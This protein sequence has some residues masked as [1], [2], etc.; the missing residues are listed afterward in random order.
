MRTTT[1]TSQ[2]PLIYSSWSPPTT[3]DP[4]MTISSAWRSTLSS[5]LFTQEREDTASRR[6]VY[7]S[8]DED[9]SSSPSSS[10]G[11]VRT[12]RL[13]TDQFDSQILNV[14]VELQNEICCT[15]DSRDFEDAESV[16]CGQSHVTS[17][18]VFSHL[19]QILGNSE[20]PATMSRQVFGTRMVRR[21]TFVHK[22]MR[23]LQ[24]LI[25]KNW[26]ME[27]IDR[28]VAPFIHSGQKWKAR[29][30]SRSEMPVWTVSHRFSHLQ[31]RRLFK[32]LWDRPTTT[33]DFWFPLWQIS[34]TSNL[35][36]LED[37]VQNRGMY[38]FK[39]SYG[40]NAMDQRSGVGW[41]SGWIEIFVIFSWYFNAEFWSTWCE[42]SFS[43]EPNHPCFSRSNG[44]TC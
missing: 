31:W 26:I 23:H 27:F 13:V 3:T 7:H 1:H 14:R 43:I 20:S 36:L 22:Q 24:L 44:E 19:I 40:S 18:P 17:Q 16:R 5:S 28:R 10:V 15:N 4:S 37:K 42:D 2:R 41:F 8:P 32:E 6:Q 39:I 29:T 35:C 25:L 33:A 34:Y 21:Q 30:K 11:H 38:L 9:L 12:G